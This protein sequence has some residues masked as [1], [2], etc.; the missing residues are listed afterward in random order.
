MARLS[1]HSRVVATLLAGLV[2]CLTISGAVPARAEGET[3]RSFTFDG[4]LNADGSLTATQT[5][6]FDE[7]PDSITQRLSPDGPTGTP[8]PR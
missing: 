2:A 4:A 8:S 3:A 7:A 1:T 5:L 6:V